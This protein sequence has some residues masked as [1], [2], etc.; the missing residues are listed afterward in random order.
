MKKAKAPAQE[1]NTPLLRSNPRNMT[2]GDGFL[3]ASSP[4]NK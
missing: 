3:R 1:Q 2:L 4:A